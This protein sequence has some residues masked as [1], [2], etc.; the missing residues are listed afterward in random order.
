MEEESGESYFKSQVDEK[1][2]MNLN[3]GK[4]GN[5]QVI[6]AS[7]SII[8]YLQ[9]QAKCQMKKREEETT[10]ILTIRTGVYEKD[11]KLLLEKDFNRCSSVNFEKHFL[12]NVLWEKLR[13]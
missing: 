13:Q 7:Y 5:V 3:V 8:Y 4:L 2:S 6:L 11:G 10:N 9:E 12:I 1:Y